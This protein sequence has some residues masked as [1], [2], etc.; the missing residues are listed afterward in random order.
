MLDLLTDF[1]EKVVYPAMETL[2]KDN[3]EDI[4]EELG[5]KI[6]AI[7]LRLTKI[8]DHQSEKLDDHDRRLVSLEEVAN[9][10]G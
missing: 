5:A 10:A 1:H 6:D 7:D 3:G 9:L 2:V 4:K 8:I